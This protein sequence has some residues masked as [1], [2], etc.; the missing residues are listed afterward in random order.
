M[1]NNRST[2]TKS[3]KLDCI[4]YP[5]MDWKVF[6][7]IIKVLQNETIKASNQNVRICNAYYSLG[8]DKSWLEKEYKKNKIRN[9]LYSAAREHCKYQYSGA[10]NMISDRIYKNYFCGE[11]SWEKKIKKGDGN[12]PMSFTKKH[13]IYI[14]ALGPNI[15]CVNKEK[16][17]YS[18]EFPL[19]NKNAKGNIHGTKKY[20]DESGKWVTEIIPIDINSNR[21]KFRFRTRKRGD[22]EEVMEKLMDK[23]SGY[24]IGDSSMLSKWNKRKRRMEYYFQLTYSYDKDD[25]ILKTLDPDRIMGI[26]LGWA[27]PAYATISDDIRQKLKYGSS[28]H[29]KQ[30]CADRKRRSDRQRDM[31]F[32]SRNGHGRKCK[33]DSDCN[34]DTHKTRNRNDTDNENWSRFIVD[35]AI[36]YRVGVIKMEDLT[37]ITRQEKD[38]KNLGDWDYFSLQQKIIQK[39]NEV[40]IT[41]MKVNRRYTSQTCPF[42]GKKDPKNRPKGKYGQAYFKCIECGYQD[43]AD[44]VAAIN[45]SRAEPIK[46]MIYPGWVEEV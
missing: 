1:S 46:N 39:A 25:A 20:M 40:G 26:D 32:N 45:I 9:V 21:L 28:K 38:E 3:I 13:P 22:L 41:V 16:G 6:D 15:E 23:N 5:T 2:K 7:E 44:H 24:K 30:A 31:K 36:K 12:P 34:G 43:N 14:R 29:Y 8:K 17:Y 11:N 10:A 33:Y 4:D 27:V 19:L 42:C 18:L 35:D 37:G